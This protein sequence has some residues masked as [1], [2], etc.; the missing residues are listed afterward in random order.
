MTIYWGTTSPFDHT[1]CSEQFSV[2]IVHPACSNL[3]YDGVFVFVVPQP[4]AQPRERSSSRVGR[5]RNKSPCRIYMHYH[6]NRTGNISLQPAL[7]KLATP[8]LHGA[9]RGTWDRRH[10]WEHRPVYMTP[11]PV[12]T[13]LGGRRVQG[14]QGGPG[15]SRGSRVQDAGRSRGQKNVSS[16]KVQ[17]GALGAPTATPRPCTIGIALRSCSICSPSSRGSKCMYGNVNPIPSLPLPPGLAPPGRPRLGR[18]IRQEQEP[19]GQPR[20]GRPIRQEQD[21]E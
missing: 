12:G 5:R 6:S 20:L 1:L 3:Q 18:P 4:V 15:G 8:A 13:H 16:S 10:E 14:V 7:I 2:L 11:N 17:G 19:P 21:G 9:N